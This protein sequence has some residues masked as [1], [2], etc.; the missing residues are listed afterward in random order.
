MI[1]F[2]KVERIIMICLTGKKQLSFTKNHIRNKHGFT[3]IELLIVIAI[4]SLLVSILL[5][6][7]STAKD[8]AKTAV[9]MTNA[10]NIGL[11][12]Q[13]YANDF[14]GKAP[15][16]YNLGGMW[17]AMN[18]WAGF[19]MQTYYDGS[20]EPFNC[21]V[22]EGIFTVALNAAAIHYG[23]NSY[24]YGVPGTNFSD[25]RCWRG[26]LEHMPQPGEIIL[27]ADTVKDITNPISGWYYVYDYFPNIHPRHNGGQDVN[28]LYCD[29][30][31]AT[32][33]GEYAPE[34][35]EV[36]HPFHKSHFA[37]LTPEESESY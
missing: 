29:G 2:W 8:L 27:V 23:Y 21:P 20:I 35:G 19:F 31:V 34:V 32:N 16:L 28:T 4:I 14:E 25:P 10:K 7:L 1:V 15:P 33:N 24:I 37:D 17:P 22:A 13:F 11:T 18:T 6:A 36:K 26:T 12:F 5:P 9:C 3:L 30:H